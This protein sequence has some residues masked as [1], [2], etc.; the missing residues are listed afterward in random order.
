MVECITRGQAAGSMS[1][2][3]VNHTKSSCWKPRYMRMYIFFIYVKDGQTQAV[4]RSTKRLYYT[5]TEKPCPQPDVRY[6]MYGQ[7][8]VAVAL[9]VN[10]NEPRGSFTTQNQIRLSSSQE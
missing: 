2:T 1:S 7:S 5:K 3:S 4:T 9:V 8:V 10:S 6:Q